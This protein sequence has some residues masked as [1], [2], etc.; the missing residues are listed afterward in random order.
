[1]STLLGPLQ[2]NMVRMDWG[3]LS[4]EGKPGR[5]RIHNEMAESQFYHSKVLRSSPVVPSF[6]LLE[7]VPCAYTRELI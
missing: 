7:S 6:L 4:A 3:A 5:F 2:M 1:M